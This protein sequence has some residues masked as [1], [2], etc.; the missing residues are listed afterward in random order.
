M[1]AAAS[2]GDIF[3]P[4]GPALRRL[5]RFF[6][7]DRDFNLIRK[8]YW[9]SKGQTGLLGQKILKRDLHHWLIPQADRE[10]SRGIR[11]AGFNWIELPSFEGAFHRTLNLNQWMGFAQ[12]W[13]EVRAAPAIFAEAA[14]RMAILAALPASAY[15]GYEVQKHLE[16][17]E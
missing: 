15:L 2:D 5:K 10:I 16:G 8:E 14:I 17:N 9:S 1:T 3:E 13:G 7:D 6:Y 11:N 4:S 12:N